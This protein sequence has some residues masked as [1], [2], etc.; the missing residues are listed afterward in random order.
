MFGEAVP[1]EKRKL[2][3]MAISPKPLL[4]FLIF[5]RARL[6]RKPGFL[7]PVVRWLS[8]WKVV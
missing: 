2:G 1:T 7:L 8:G 3:K 6:S 4:M 5:N